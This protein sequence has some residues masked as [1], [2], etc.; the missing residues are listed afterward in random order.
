MTGTPYQKAIFYQLAA[1]VVNGIALSQSK[2]S[3]GNFTLNGSLV[4]AGVATLDSGG[5]ARRVLFTFAAD[6]TGHSFTVTGTDRYGRPQS[7][8]VSGNATTAFTTK[9]YLTVTQV[10]V[11]SA[12]TGNVQIGTNGVGSSTPLIVD[13]FVNPANYSCATVATGTVNYTVE[14][15]SDDLAPA[16]DL[17]NNSPTWYPTP[18]FNTQ[19]TSVDGIISGPC[20]MIRLTINSGTGSV[21]A[22]IIMPFVA[23]GF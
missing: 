12:T 4:S 16:W 2:G 15:S 19:T 17:A 11:A 8:V 22:R 3:A 1:S 23:G 7:E 20:T 14:K 18:T 9:D 13:A 5:S 6:E 10:S 21:T